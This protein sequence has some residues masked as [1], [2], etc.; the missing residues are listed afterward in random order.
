MAID[1]LPMPVVTFLNVIGVKWPYI[2]E[3]S[4][5]QFGDLVNEFGQ[6]VELT[7]QDATATVKQ[8]GAVYKGAAYTQLHN[9]WTQ[10]SASHVSELVEACQA[11]SAACTAAAAYIVEQKGEAIVELIG[12][13]AT[14]L[15]A[16]AAAVETFGLSE[17]AAVLADEVAE[18]L[19]E[20]LEQ[21][22]EQYLIGKLASEALKPLIAK[23]EAAMSGLDWPGGSG[24][25]SV[26]ASFE[27]DTTAM[28]THASTLH[29]HADM[30]AGHT[31]RFASGAASINVG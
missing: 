4:L 1:D 22:L 6:A 8:L 15:A 11:V 29:A 14:F 18:R 30:F 9:K 20:S 25:G 24:P 13:A 2:N 21:D 10:M 3:D 17:A 12:L 19:I 16:Q 26:E 27:A 23:V 7:H 28:M 31:Q 5:I